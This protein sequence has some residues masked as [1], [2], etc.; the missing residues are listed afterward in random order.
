MDKEKVI[1]IAIGLA[2]GIIFAG[3]YFG[4]TK[5]LPALTSPK[6][7]PAVFQQPVATV[8]ANLVVNSPSDYSTTDSPVATVS[9]LAK[10]GATL[11]ILANADD[12]IAS[13]DAT[14]KF[15]T[16]VKLESG[17]NAIGVSDLSQIVTRTVILEI[18]PWNKFA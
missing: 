2:T 1:T 6:T 17:Q 13:A 10:P 9:G 4:I 18:N 12:K 14:G 16:T 8:S 3:L 15:S 11:L 7:P 5:Y